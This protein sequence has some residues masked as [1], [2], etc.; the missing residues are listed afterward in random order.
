MVK[1][2]VD[3][4]YALAKQNAKEL[5]P[6]VSDLPDDTTSESDTPAKTTPA[7]SKRSRLNKQQRMASTISDLTSRLEKAE[8]KAADNAQK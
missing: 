5:K 3:A 4:D 2:K 8:Q 1:E 7:K 6:Y